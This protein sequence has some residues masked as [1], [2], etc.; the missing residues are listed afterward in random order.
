MFALGKHDFMLKFLKH[1]KYGNCLVV[2]NKTNKFKTIVK[3]IFG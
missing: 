2:H 3:K 1:V